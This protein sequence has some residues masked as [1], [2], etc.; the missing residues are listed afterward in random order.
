MLG[1][2]IIGDAG[3]GPAWNEK[4]MGFRNEEGA[5]TGAEGLGVAVL[6]SGFLV[7]KA[8]NLEWEET[9]LAASF[10]RWAALSVWL[11]QFASKANLHV[12][13]V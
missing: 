8:V 9:L 5:A 7:K 3:K 11:V 6:S 12:A 4:K 1:V 10:L 2:L 13:F